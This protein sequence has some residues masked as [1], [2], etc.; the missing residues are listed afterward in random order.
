M[1]W[2]TATQPKKHVVHRYSPP[3]SSPSL[4]SVL[5]DKESHFVTASGSNLFPRPSSATGSDDLFVKLFL[6]LTNELIVHLTEIV[7][8]LLKMNRKQQTS[9]MSM[10]TTD[11]VTPTKMLTN[12]Y[13]MIDYLMK[14]FTNSDFVIALLIQPIKEE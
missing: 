6:F 12:L 5:S 2:F 11:M 13:S 1:D 8:L 14:I 3:V 4:T 7:Q 9:L 10:Q